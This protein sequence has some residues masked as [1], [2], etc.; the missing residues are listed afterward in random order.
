MID[1]ETETGMETS[2]ERVVDDVDGHHSGRQNSLFQT[3]LKDEIVLL[4]CSAASA[5]A[6]GSATEL[7]RRSSKKAGVCRGLESKKDCLRDLVTGMLVRR[8][9]I[10]KGL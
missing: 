6:P 3:F 9:A 2:N 7:L 10:L 1:M 5:S 8:R 4:V